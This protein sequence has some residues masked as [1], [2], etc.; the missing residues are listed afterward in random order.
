M[1]EDSQI[2]ISK[3]ERW[4]SIAR[5]ILKVR[6]A[7]QEREALEDTRALKVLRDRRGNQESPDRPGNRACPDPRDSL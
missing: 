3:L 6:K 7:I 5:L 4:L 2:L 1:S